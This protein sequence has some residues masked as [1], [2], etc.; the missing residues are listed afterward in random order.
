M[1]LTRLCKA[2][3]NLAKEYQWRRQLFLERRKGV[4]RFRLQGYMA[5]VLADHMCDTRVTLPT[6]GSGIV[7]FFFVSW[8]GMDFLCLES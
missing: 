3:V 7:L 4:D 6:E 5:S 1:L 8:M 2:C